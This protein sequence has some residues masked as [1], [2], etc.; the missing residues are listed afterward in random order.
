MRNLITSYFVDL[1]TVLFKCK[2]V[3]KYLNNLKK[4]QC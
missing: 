2:I 1:S 3:N 4:K